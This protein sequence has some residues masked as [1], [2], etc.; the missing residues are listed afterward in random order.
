MSRSIA[1]RTRRG[2]LLVATP[3]PRHLA[4]VR[5]GLG[6]LNVDGCKDERLGA[7]PGEAF[8]Q[9]SSQAHE[10][11]MRPVTSERV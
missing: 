1:L 5:A 3:T 10:H 6:P 7:T 2:A 4:E 11:E 8:A 9:V